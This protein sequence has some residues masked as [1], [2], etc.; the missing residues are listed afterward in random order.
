MLLNGGTCPSLASAYSRSLHHIVEGI[1]ADGDAATFS[2][3]SSSTSPLIMSQLSAPPPRSISLQNV[4]RV[5]VHLQAL[6]SCGALSHESVTSLDVSGVSIS[7]AGLTALGEALSSS[8]SRLLSL[9]LANTAIGDAGALQLSNGLELCP[10]PSLR[11]INVRGC[12]LT[13]S[14]VE[15]LGSAISSLQNFQSLCLAANGLP[16]Q[17]GVALGRLLRSRSGLQS[18]DLSN[19]ELGDCGA[20]ALGGAIAADTRQLSTAPL[21]VTSLDLSS[22]GI[23]DDGVAALCRGLQAQLDQRSS[24]STL[25][26]LR[27]RDNELTAAGMGIIS[28]FLRLEES[29]LTAL[30]VGGNAAIGSEGLRWLTEDGGAWVHPRLESLELEGVVNSVEAM[31]ELGRCLESCGVKLRH[32]DVSGKAP[33]DVDAHERGLV[34]LGRAVS[35]SSTLVSLVLGDWENG[36]GAQADGGAAALRTMSHTLAMNRQGSPEGEREAPHDGDQEGPA[37]GDGQGSGSCTPPSISSFHQIRREHSEA[38]ERLTLEIQDLSGQLPL[39]PAASARI[40]E[41][42]STGD[43]E[44]IAEEAAARAV[45]E[46]RREWEQDLG[47]VILALRDEAS[48]QAQEV[49]MQVVD[50]AAQDLRWAAEESREEGRRMWGGQVRNLENNLQNLASQ[51][52]SLAQ[53][54]RTLER[55]AVDAKQSQLSPSVAAGAVH[56]T[57]DE[58]IALRVSVLEEGSR[59]LVD[60]VKGLERSMSEANSQIDSLQTLIVEEKTSTLHLLEAILSTAS[61]GPSLKKVECEDE[62]GS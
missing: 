27:L 53:R 59:E 41:F 7:P 9:S 57:M 18:L 19:N 32:L 24:P 15:A 31:L 16:K 35:R 2:P 40:D 60:T 23:G 8:T 28:T 48:N 39:A 33:R 30:D 4:P 38:L 46:A 61:L 22:N 55:V 14:G 5:G 1:A 29:S 13:Q 43:A 17:A 12:N 47:G 36:A 52:E 37:C 44:R 34:A 54:I 11:H 51:L 10:S 45:A 62:L 58:N 3:S 56:D 42:I 6:G 25:R 20:A 26:E 50:K 49:V 21:S